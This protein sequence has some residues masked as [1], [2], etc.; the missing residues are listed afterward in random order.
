MNCA[1]TICAKNY[2]GL[3]QVLEKSLRKYDPEIVFLIF[4][5]D[6]YENSKD[7]TNLP[8]NIIFC[9]NVLSSLIKSDVWEN[10]SFKYNLTEFCT[11]LKPFCFEYL[12]NSRQYEKVIFLD[13]DIY[14]YSSIQRIFNILDSHKIILTPHIANIDLDYKGERSELGL[15]STG[16]FNLGFLALRKSN[17]SKLFLDWWSNK[18]IDL[19]FIDPM[20]SIFTDQK[21]IDFLPSFFDSK[22]LFIQREL[23]YNVAPWNFF[24][25]Q[26]VNRSNKYFVKS[27]NLNNEFEDELVFVHYSGFDYISMLKNKVDQKNIQNLREYEDINPLYRIYSNALI[28]NS[29]NI[30]EYLSLKYSYNYFDNESIISGFHRRLYSSLIVQNYYSFQSSPFITN[31]DSFYRNLLKNNLINNKIIQSEKSTK[32]SFNNLNNKLEIIHT[33]MKFIFRIIGPNNY[34]LLVK[35]FGP[36][37][38]FENHTFIIKNETKGYLK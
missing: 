32:D 1:F 31:G 11:A 4:V 6:E 15:L 16:V 18:L 27:R 24:E 19:C 12:F 26:I 29:K 33:V 38:R 37:S 23:G 35:F 17:E 5:A 25:R 8:D 3:A 28:E 14:F 7:C 34:I 9:R 20:D 36:F 21:W 10:M 22:I 2:I 13:P 30:Y